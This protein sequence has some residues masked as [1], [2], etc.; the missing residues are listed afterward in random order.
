MKALKAAYNRSEEPR[1][2][3]YRDKSGLEVDLIREYQ[4]RHRSADAHRLTPLA[5]PTQRNRD[6]RTAGPAPRDAATESSPRR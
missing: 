5:S 2:S 4:R 3:F 6:P 1:L